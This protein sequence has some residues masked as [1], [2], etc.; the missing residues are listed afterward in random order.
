MKQRIGDHFGTLERKARLLSTFANANRLHMLQLLAAGE[1]S[2]GELAEKVELSQSAVSQ[3]LALL[4]EENIV[5]ARRDSQTKYYAL[6]SEA[7][8]TLLDTLT[9]IFELQLQSGLGN[10]LLGDS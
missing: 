7:A 3:H 5:K 10:F 6:E 2:V 8:R 4:R 1:M 9:D